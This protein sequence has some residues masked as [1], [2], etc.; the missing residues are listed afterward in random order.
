MRRVVGLAATLG[1]VVILGC[2]DRSMTGPTLVGTADSLQV[3]SGNNQSGVVSTPLST[4]LTVQVRTSTGVA[5][6]GTSVTFSVATGGGSVSP[7][8]VSTD[9]TGRAQTT[10]T[11]GAT[12]GQ[13]TVTATAGAKVITLSATGIASGSTGGTT[14]G[15]LPAAQV[16]LNAGNGQT[17]AIGQPLGAN[18]VVKVLDSLGNAVSGT[19]VTFA[20]GAGNGT[21]GSSSPTSIKSDAGGLAT[22]QW[23]LGSKVGQQTLTATVAGLTPVT[24]Q[25]TGT[26]GSSGAAIV[27]NGNSQVAGSGAALPTYL[28][29]LVVDQAGNPALGARVTWAVASGGGS[30]SKSSGT[31]NA[32]GLDSARWTLGSTI[33]AQTVTATVAN[34]GSVTYAATATTVSGTPATLRIISGE[35][36]SGQSAQ[37][38]ALPIVVEVRDAGGNVLSGVTVG[39]VQAATNT[40]AVT[41]PSPAVTGVDG[42]ASVTWRLGSNTGTTVQTDSLTASLT[43]YPAIAG[44]VFHASV[45]PAF[46]IRMV[47]LADTVQTDTTGATL[48]DTL[49][50]KVYD[51]VTGLGVQGIPISWATQAPTSSDG[52]AINS[53]D[54][55]DNTGLA[56]NRWALRSSADGAAI[57]SSAVAKRMVATATGIGQVEFKAHVYPGALRT[58]TTNVTSSTTMVAGNAVTWCATGKDVT[59]NIIDSVSFVFAGSGGGSS[60]S[61][62]VLSI[63]GAATCVASTITAAGSWGFSVSG[64]AQVRPYAQSNAVA[65]V[66]SGSVVV[67]PAAAATMTKAAGDAQ[68]AKVSTALP[69]PLKVLV[70]DSFGNVVPGQAVSFA[71]VG[72]GG[73]LSAGGTPAATATATTGADGTASVTLIL[74]AAAGTNTVVATAGGGTVI[75]TATGTP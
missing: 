39:F 67:S 44:V 69:T 25:A 64:T 61:S 31:T 7:A 71:V 1:A 19:T 15:A 57:P 49:V 14:A 36:Q 43:G 47:N 11:L 21:G 68:S 33:G 46:R 8:V 48:V 56:K 42:R 20:Q 13:Q 72:G 26:I 37:T 24:V 6:V 32:A 63:Y 51:P 70:K 41:T 75:F 59:G 62:T 10:W 18:V 27:D 45:R 16:V 4:P 74:G 30:I 52:F 53:V 12:T 2:M 34:V 55:T 50:V 3:A 54:T 58:I 35:G 65:A 28:R 40:D 66:S 22:T 9:A 29:V 5:V 17:G 60:V 73:L 38:L 23:T